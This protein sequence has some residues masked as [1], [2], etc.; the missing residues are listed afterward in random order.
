MKKKLL[1]IVAVV[2]LIMAVGSTAHAGQIWSA[3]GY[4][5]STDITF[6]SSI[7]TGRETNG[8]PVGFQIVDQ[9]Q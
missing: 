4:L 9:I 8:A 7:V 2:V 3:P 6:N 5:P 1:A